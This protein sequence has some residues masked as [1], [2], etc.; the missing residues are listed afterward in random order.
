MDPETDTP[1]AFQRFARAHGA[2]GPGWTFLGGPKASV[3][4]VLRKLGEWRDDPADHT[5]A[6]IAGNSRSRH[7]TRIRP[8]AGPQAVAEVLRGLDAERPPATATAPRVAE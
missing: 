6:F 5:T 8:D 3:A 4:A 2:T 1:E 7:W